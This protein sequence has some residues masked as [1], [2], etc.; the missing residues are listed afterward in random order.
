MQSSMQFNDYNAFHQ[1]YFITIAYAIY[2]RTIALVVKFMVDLA[3]KGGKKFHL[4]IL[5]KLLTVNFFHTS[6]IHTH[7]TIMPI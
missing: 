3:K 1:I 4:F 6:T 2:L 7:L 5:F